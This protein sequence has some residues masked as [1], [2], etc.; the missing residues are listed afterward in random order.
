MSAAVWRRVERSDGEG[1]VMKTDLSSA[2][3]LVWMDGLHGMS[4]TYRMNSSGLR[5]A[6]C[7]TPADRGAN[8]ET[9]LSTLVRCLLYDK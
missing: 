1:S 6:P 7:G 5:I 2:K 3:R 4:F 8:P 9:A